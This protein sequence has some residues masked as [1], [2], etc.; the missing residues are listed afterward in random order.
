M[1]NTHLL[2]KFIFVAGLLSMLPVSSFCQT[3]IKG[4]IKD[5]AG[6]AISSASVSII[7]Q[8]TETGIDF[9]TTNERGEYYFNLPDSVSISG[10]AVRVNS[11]GFLRSV[12]SIIDKNSVVDFVLRADISELPTVTVKNSGP[13][14]RIKGDTLSYTAAS[15]ADKGD[16]VIGDIIR[17]L[18]GIEVDENGTIK[19]QGKPIN[20]FYIDGDNILDDKYTIATKN[21]PSDI[22]EKIQVIENNQHIKMLNGIVR[23]ERAA[24][25][26]TL[27]DNAKL[28]LVNTAKAGA[29]VSDV[30]EAELNSM[31]FK[32]RFKAIN[33]L[34]YNNT[35]DDPSDEVVSHN[36]GDLANSLEN[37]GT[38]NLLTLGIAGQPNIPKKRFLFNHAGLINV[39]DFFKTKKDL[40]IRFNGHSILGRQDQGYEYFAT[41]YLPFDTVNYR[42]SQQIHRNLQ[43]L[44]AALTANINTTKRYINN[45][46]TFDYSHASDKSSL[47]TIGNLISQQLKGSLH[48]LTNNFNNVILIGNQKFIELF[49]FT[50]YEAKPQK[51]SIT[52]GLH[53]VL[54]NKNNAFRQ[55]IQQVNIPAFFTNNYVSFKTG[56]GQFFQTYKAGILYQTA[57]LIS[58]LLAEQFDNTVHPISDTFSNQLAW[59]KTK[60][61]SEASFRWEGKSS[62]LTF[63]LPAGYTIIH[64]GDTHMQQ[65]SGTNRVLVTP[66]IR[67]QNK[68]GRQNMVNAS[69]Q[70]STQLSNLNEIYRGVIMNNYQSFVSNDIPIQQTHNYSYNAGF[71]FKR[72]IKLLFINMLYTYSERQADFIYA[73]IL[74]NNIMRREIVPLPNRSFTTTL[75]LNI[76]KYLYSLK[77]SV[78]TKYSYQYTKL[79]QLQNGNLFP[80][81]YSSH[82][83]TLNAT[84]KPAGFFTLN[85]ESLYMWTSSQAGGLQTGKFG[86]S[87][88][89]YSKHNLEMNVFLAERFS[90]KLRTELYYY[91]QPSQENISF[92]FSD[93][94]IRYNL[95]KSSTDI[96]LI[97]SNLS[98]TDRFRTISAE[99][100]SISGTNYLLRPRTILLRASFCF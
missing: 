16:R 60:F 96:E 81:A 62:T 9:M 36:N 8:K 85:Y 69:Y 51:L 47:V 46:L 29:G 53:Q 33:V 31:A 94:S 13:Y 30:M 97:C 26:I 87:R 48:R 2:N 99:D 88:N 59:G 86:S 72:S 27:K 49:S 50:S 55:S 92:L 68:V 74:R 67:W 34:K 91:N 21:I 18:P 28:N 65:I 84:V 98:N 14:L 57:D 32:S 73:S 25:N 37:R 70:Y 5:S 4:T 79:Q 6:K 10:L 71:D 45:T 54:L 77:T 75:S 43:T 39:N 61:Y 22:V 1:Q 35:G 11:I 38:E 80:V 93:A 15:F 58:S 89:Y 17:K 19:Y 66:A 82:N 20:Y 78:F 44:H 64:Y 56:N 52:P 41:Y 40:N 24:L 83:F 3:Y 23:S 63:S 76:S 7:E 100:N 42:E 12:K 90:T 95:K